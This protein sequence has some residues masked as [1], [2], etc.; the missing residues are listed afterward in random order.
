MKQIL[1]IGGGTGGIMTAAQL[2]KKG[3]V[4]ITLVDPSEFH[5]Y[6]PAWTLVGA[7]A[8]DFEKTKRTMASVMPKGVHWIKE[9]VDKLDPENNQVI[10]QS[11]SV[12]TYD[13]LVLSPG[14]KLD[15]SLIKG[16]P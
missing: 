1:I 8:F 12:L 7:D 14:I 15:N 4:K 5:Y 10:T 2:L 11:G 13:F 9:F 16:L 6:Q 3:G